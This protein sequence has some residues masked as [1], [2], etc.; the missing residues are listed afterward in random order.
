MV[1][2]NLIQ[3]GLEL[4][5]YG[6]GTVVIFLTLLVFVTGLMSSIVQRYLPA[7][8]EPEAPVPVAD[9]TLVAVISAAIHKHR[10]RHDR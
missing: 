8:P 7:A 3:Q 4:M 9:T 6:M 5:L 10:S 2:E 1:E